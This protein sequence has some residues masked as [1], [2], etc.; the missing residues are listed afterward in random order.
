M[1][2]PITTP[3]G[4]QVHGDPTRS[5]TS[6][7]RPSNGNSATGPSRSASRR[8]A[9]RISPSVFNATNTVN[10]DPDTIVGNTT[11]VQFGQGGSTLHPLY[12]PRQ[13]QIGLRASF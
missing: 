9:A 12:Q 6:T 1:K 7:S 2:A 11:S 3:A 10:V 8:A 13:V 4:T 5:C